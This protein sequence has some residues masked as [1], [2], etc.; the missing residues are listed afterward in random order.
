MQDGKTKIFVLVITVTSIVIALCGALFLWVQC[1][2]VEKNWQPFL[3]GTCWHPQVSVIIGIVGGTYSTISD[4]IF[5][6]LPWK[7]VWGLQMQKKEKF[8]VAI[9]MSMGVLYVARP[10]LHLPLEPN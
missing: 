1:S 9:A 6:L 10:P 4:W 5:A 8:G 7:L 3:P 2:P